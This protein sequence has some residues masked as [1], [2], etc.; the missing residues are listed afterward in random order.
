MFAVYNSLS[1]VSDPVV[2]V[3]G[4]VRQSEG[5]VESAIQAGVTVCWG[6]YCGE[7]D[8]TREK[9][10]RTFMVCNGGMRWEGWEVRGDGCLKR[11]WSGILEAEKVDVREF[12]RRR[13]SGRMSSHDLRIGCEVIRRR[14]REQVNDGF[15]D[16]N[17]V[18][19]YAAASSEGQ[20]AESQADA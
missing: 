4:S 17:D 16:E 2:V 10:E 7:A 15:R 20:L 1:F 18:M 19:F 8:T 9:F 13:G 12:D 6:D 5:I 11:Q 14:K 3:L